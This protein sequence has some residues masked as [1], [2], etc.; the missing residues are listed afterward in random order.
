MLDYFGDET[1]SKR[2]L[3]ERLPRLRY[4]PHAREEF[5]ATIIAQKIL[6]AIIKTS[7]RFGIAHVSAVLLGSKRKK[8]L[9][10]GHGSLS[11][12]GIVDDFDRNEIREIASLLVTEGL[13]YTKQ[14]RIFDTRCH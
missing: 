7:Q 12:Y 9:E 6:S 2:C 10:L 14:S 5:D 3:V 4:L 13:I 1:V 8:V 11:V